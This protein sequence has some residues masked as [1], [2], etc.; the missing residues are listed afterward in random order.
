M[1]PSGFDLALTHSAGVGCNHF[2]P[3]ITFLE[4]FDFSLA[5]QLFFFFITMVQN[6]VTARCR[7]ART[8]GLRM[9]MHGACI[10]SVHKPTEPSLGVMRAD[11]GVAPLSLFGDP[12]EL[13]PFDR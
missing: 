12:Y 7:I 9:P 4:P 13:D 2:L 1:K 8:L 6:E 5:D 3:K 10:L 11:V